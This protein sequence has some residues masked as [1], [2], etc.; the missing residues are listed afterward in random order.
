MNDKPNPPTIVTAVC[1]TVMGLLAL[2]G[3]LIMMKS[4]CTDFLVFISIVANV[5]LADGSALVACRSG[6]RT[7]LRDRHRLLHRMEEPPPAAA[8]DVITTTPTEI[9]SRPRDGGQATE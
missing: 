6:D 8:K 4:G 2:A 9:K 5:M 3:C 1:S 7:T